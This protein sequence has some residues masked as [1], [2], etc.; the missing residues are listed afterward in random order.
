MKEEYIIDA[1]RTLIGN[2]EGTLSAV[3][4]DCYGPI[5]IRELLERYPKIINL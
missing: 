4:T 5:P 3:R 2:F 1:I